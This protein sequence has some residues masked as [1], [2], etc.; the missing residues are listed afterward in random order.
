[1]QVQG[2]AVPGILPFPDLFIQ[3]FPEKGYIF[4][5]YKKHQK[6]ELLVGQFHV[7]ACPGDPA[8]LHVHGHIAGR[9]QTFRLIVPAEHRLHPGHQL[10]H[11]KGLYQIVV[12]AQTQS[13]YPVLHL[14]PGSDKNHRYIHGTDVAHDIVPIHPR[15]HDVQQNQVKELSLYE[16]EG[17]HPV[18]D[19]CA[20]VTAGRQV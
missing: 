3:G 13:L 7:P 2:A 14:M 1:M 17:L 12:R 10:H 19:S 6:T 8:C 15:Q 9:K 5:L 20:L 11:V 16:P 18:L 4:I